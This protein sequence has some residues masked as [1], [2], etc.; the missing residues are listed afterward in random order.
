MFVVF[1]EGCMRSGMVNVVRVKILKI[2]CRLIW[3]LLWI[4][5]KVR[6]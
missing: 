4:V 3:I 6:I 5:L 2:V 1:G